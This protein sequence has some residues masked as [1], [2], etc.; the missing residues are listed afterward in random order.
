M[1]GGDEPIVLIE[2]GDGGVGLLRQGQ[3]G[4]NVARVVAGVIEG[5]A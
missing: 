3:D 1:H 4:L 2:Q 5:V